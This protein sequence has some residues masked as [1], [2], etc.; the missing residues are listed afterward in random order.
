M[1]VF[2]YDDPYLYQSAHPSTFQPTAWSLILSLPW[3]D[4]IALF[5]LNLWYVSFF[6]V[7]FVSTYPLMIMDQASAQYLGTVVNGVTFHKVI[8]SRVQLPKPIAS[9]GS[10]TYKLEWRA[11]P[12]TQ[13]IIY[14]MAGDY[15]PLLISSCAHSQDLLFERCL[16]SFLRLR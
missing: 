8:D 4:L 12:E 10:P 15:N 3:L 7:L 2:E 6:G 1:C 5:T 9:L 13:G 11:R 14:R 16:S